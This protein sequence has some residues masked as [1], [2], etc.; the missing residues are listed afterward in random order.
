MVCHLTAQI[1]VETPALPVRSYSTQKWHEQI[2]QMPGVA[3][4]MADIERY[5][6]AFRT[7]GVIDR[8]NVPVVVHLMPL[9]SD[10]PAITESDVLAQLERLNQDFLEPRH[11]Y[12][13]DNYQQP[14][15]ILNEQGGIVGNQSDLQTYIRDTDKTEGFAQRAGNPLIKF[16]LVHTDPTGALSSGIVTGTGG[17][18]IWPMT[19]DLTQSE[20]AWPAKNYLNIWVARLDEAAGAG[21]AQMP[22]GPQETDGIVIDDRFFLRAA[23]TDQPNVTLSHLVASYLNL[24]ELWNDTKHCQDDFVDDTPIHNAPNVGL[25]YPNESRHVSTCEGN[26][27][28]MRSNIMDNTGDVSQ[29]LFTWGQIM[30][31]H[32]TLS[33]NGP[34]GELRKTELTCTLDEGL[35]QEGQGRTNKATNTSE[36]TQWT[37]TISPNPTLDQFTITVKNLGSDVLAD[38]RVYDN[39][40]HELAHQNILADA[41]GELTARFSAQS[42]GTGLYVVIVRSGDQ[43]ETLRVIVE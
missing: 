26:P 3:D 22:G 27:V 31:M 10:A 23:Q 12:T 32:A 9:P 42:W 6:F 33:P 40:G 25:P 13:T 17:E 29:Y 21:W 4:Q 2:R 34:R 18:R 8:V 5:T 14:A 39:G 15:L 11:P 38:I 1:I 41:S 36:K 37:A 28:E 43:Q 30:R 35:V 16:C 7:T 20:P 24:Y 19:E